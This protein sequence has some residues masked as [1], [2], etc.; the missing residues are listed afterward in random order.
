VDKCPF[1]HG[2]VAADLTLHGGNCPHCFAVIPGEETPTDPGEQVK[3]AIAEQD[4]RHAEKRA[5]GPVIALSA[6]AAVAVVFSVYVAWPQEKIA[7]VQ[8]DEA[9]FDAGFSMAPVGPAGG[10]AS[11]DAPLASNS[12]SGK[13]RAPGPETNT[14]GVFSVG[15]GS[16]RPSSS[17][18][19]SAEP[20]AED[21]S[22]ALGGAGGRSSSE[23]STRPPNAP[24]SSITAPA[25]GSVDMGS[26]AVGGFGSM[27]APTAGPARRAVVLTEPTEIAGAV[28]RLVRAKQKSATSCYERRLK[29][30]E[31]LAGVWKVQVVIDREGRVTA[32][33]ASG[34]VSDPD[35]EACLVQKISTWQGDFALKEPLS[36]D[37]PLRFSPE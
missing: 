25:Q 17:G 11:P 14:S 31:D 5:R 29:I 28:K 22:A 32:R 30:V 18:T 35:L 36:V 13:P 2:A 23:P 21:I 33:S 4:K 12:A 37:F 15:S 16:N 7:V 20:T 8:F 10:S 1:C 34:S 6:M 24:L 19:G 26:A 9:M 27:D 3:K